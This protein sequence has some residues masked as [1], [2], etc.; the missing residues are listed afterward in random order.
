MRTRAGT[1]ASI[2]ALVIS[3][4]WGY[5]IGFLILRNNRPNAWYDMDFSVWVLCALYALIHLFI[6]KL[7]SMFTTTL[8]NIIEYRTHRNLLQHWTED[9]QIIFGSLW[10]VSVPI[11]FLAFLFLMLFGTKIEME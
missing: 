9:R 3:F 10:P 11:A 8:I 1:L 6:G 4:G 2:I 7:W 5:F